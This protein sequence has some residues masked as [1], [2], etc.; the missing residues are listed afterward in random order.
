MT[1]LPT[2]GEGYGSS[3]DVYRSHALKALHRDA[4]G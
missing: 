3:K 2:G 1:D 4:K